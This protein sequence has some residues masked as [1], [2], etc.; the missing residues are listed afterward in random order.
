M[1][2][3]LRSVRLSRSQLAAIAVASAVATALIIASAMGRTGAESAVLAALHRRVVVHRTPVSAA[4]SAL[5]APDTAGAGSGASAP[6]PTQDASAAPAPDASASSGA[7]SSSPGATTSNTSA[8]SG[9]ATNSTGTT[10][11]AAATPAAPKPSKAK[12]V[13]VIAVSTTDFRAA[14]GRGSVE[15]YLNRTLRPLGTLLSGYHTLGE[16]PLPDAIAMTSG[17][18]PNADTERG[19]AT[20]SEFAGTAK[21]AA[22]G[23]V[24]GAGC[25]YPNTMLTIGDQVTSSAL[26]WKAYI[27]AMGSAPCRHPN[28]N[29]PD[30]SQ[31]AAPPDQYSTPHNPFVYYHSLLDL[32]DCMSDDVALDQLPGD[33]KHAA[34]TPSYTYIAPGLC[35][36][37]EALTCPDGQP[38][39]LRATDAFLARWVPVI[40]ASA[41][42]RRDGALIIAFTGSGAPSAAPRRP[43]QTGALVISRFATAGATSRA[44][45]NP[46]SVL[47]SVEDLL[48]FTP[49]AHAAHAI[50]FA[51]SV[52]RAAVR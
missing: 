3:S 23:Q 33:L 32:G 26:R 43:V 41:A 48:G 47:R 29:A 39:G 4:P 44:A 2:R 45:Y 6:S 14:F 38:G 51:A 40:L 11:P 46:Y 13:F 52:L 12:H 5:T 27:E 22:D 30:P 16:A 17:Q 42:Y 37:A 19:C 18:A 10:T 9:G 36:D 20:Y 24:P 15:T 28:S 8:G 25:V 21:P 1:I 50:S 31:L 49:L 35:E 7:S 34:T